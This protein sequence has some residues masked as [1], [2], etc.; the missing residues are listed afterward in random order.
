MP[1]GRGPNLSVE[2]PELD[3]RGAD[4]METYLDGD[5]M[6]RCDNCSALIQECVCVC[7]QCG[8]AVA[9]CS[10]DEGP[11]YPAVSDY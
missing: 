10:C 1:V 7:V 4:L 9:E 11:A 2:P 5:D 6:E 8:D 3:T